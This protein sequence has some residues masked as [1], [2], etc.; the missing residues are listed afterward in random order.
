MPYV[1]MTVVF[2]EG[3]YEVSI[4]IDDD[5]RHLGTFTNGDETGAFMAKW[6]LD[7]G[8]CFSSD[9]ARRISEAQRTGAAVLILDVEPQK[10]EET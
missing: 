2:C 8:L 4:E 7:R 1:T 3:K 10:Q 6:V 5:W 9:S